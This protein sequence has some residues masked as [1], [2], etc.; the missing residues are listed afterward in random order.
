[1]KIVSL[2]LFLPA[3]I[4]IFAFMHT[5]A[6]GIPQYLTDHSQKCIELKLIIIP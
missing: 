1:L 4:I 2:A 3:N 5:F 6:I